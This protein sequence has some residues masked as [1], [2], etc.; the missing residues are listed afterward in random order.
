V[1]SEVW[2]GTKLSSLDDRRAQDQGCK[3]IWT[4]PASRMKME[5]EHRIPLQSEA[6]RIL[7]ALEAHQKYKYVFASSKGTPLSDMTLS[8][9]MRRMHQTKIKAGQGYVDGR[10]KRPAVPHGLRSTFR[11]WASEAGYPREVA[12]LQLAHRIGS[13][14]ETAYMRTDMLLQRAAMIKDWQ[15]F[16]AGGTAHAAS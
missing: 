11:D 6:V 7:K 8:A 9:I 5:R 1:K 2:F 13:K 12:E 16:V 14:V 3:A 4:I 10:S 15:E